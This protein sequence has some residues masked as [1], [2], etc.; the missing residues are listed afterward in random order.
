MKTSGIPAQAP[1]NP[2][3]YDSFMQIEE[4]LRH[5]DRAWVSFSG[6][7]KS[8][9]MLDMVWRMADPDCVE[10]VFFDTGAEWKATVEH[11]KKVEAD[12]GIEIKREKPPKSVHDAIREKGLPVFSRTVCERVNAG[13]TWDLP[14]GVAESPPSFKVSTACCDEVKKGF[15]RAYAN[16]RGQEK[17]LCICCTK[18]GDWSPPYCHQPL[19]WYD[20][21]AY[22]DYIKLFNVELSDV[23]TLWGFKSTTCAGCPLDATVQKKLTIA[24]QFEPET[25]KNCYA[26]FGEAY[27]YLDF[28]RANQT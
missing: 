13:K 25:V 12:Y 7:K 1:E 2:L 27:R 15:F 14:R 28:M 24:R 10:Y 3:V 4:A 22:K 5:A 21:Q 9:I 23:Y 20:T 16:K 17:S 18:F 11:L 6:G 8:M 19:K 26:V